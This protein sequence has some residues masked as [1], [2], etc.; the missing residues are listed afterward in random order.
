MSDDEPL[1]LHLVDAAA[2][3]AAGEA[4][5]RVLCTGDVLALEGELGAGKTS[6][7]RGLAAGLGVDPA[8]VSSPTSSV[9]SSTS[10]PATAPGSC[11]PTRT[12]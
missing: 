8:A 5:G 1:T 4:L 2:T 3:A 10:P 12:A 11:M 7:V 9:W 6:L